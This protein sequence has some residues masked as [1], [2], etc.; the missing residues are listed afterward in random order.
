MLHLRDYEE[1]E[2]SPP[3][4]V[5]IR[6]ELLGLLVVWLVLTLLSRQE[7]IARKASQANL[8]KPENNQKVAEISEDDRKALVGLLGE[9]V[10]EKLIKLDESVQAKNPPPSQE[11]TVAFDPI[12]DRSQRATVHQVRHPVPA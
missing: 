6:F 2:P 3:S 9:S 12:T 10:A 11:R 4:Q 7:L 5:S 8:N 1:D